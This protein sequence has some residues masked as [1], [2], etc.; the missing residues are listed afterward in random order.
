MYNQKRDMS[1]HQS[2]DS[3]ATHKGGQFHQTQQLLGVYPFASATPTTHVA[4]H[5][6]NLSI[7]AAPPSYIQP[8]YYSTPSNYG[9]APMYQ[10]EFAQ[11]SAMNVPHTGP[12]RTYWDATRSDAFRLME[13]QSSTSYY[14]CPPSHWNESSAYS[15][16][17]PAPFAQSVMQHAVP[18]NVYP[19]PPPAQVPMNFSSASSSLANA[20]GSPTTNRRTSS[21]SKKQLPASQSNSTDSARFF[22]NFLNDQVKE[23]PKAVQQRNARM[24]SRPS[25]PIKQASNPDRLR[26]DSVPPS[27]PLTSL[28]DS[29][30]SPR[31]RK[32]VEVLIDTPSK[33]PS[34]SSHMGPS[35]AIQ[36]TT[37]EFNSAKVNRQIEITPSRTPKM[38]VYVEITPTSKGYV[39]PS[40]SRINEN[41]PSSDLGGYGMDYEDRDGR[42]KDAMSGARST[43]K[44]TGYRDDRVPLEK[45]LNLLEDIFE[46]E[47]NI[48][49]DVDTDS[50]PGTFFSQLSTDPARPLLHSTIIVRLTKAISKVARPTKRIR[51]ASVQWEGTAPGSPRKAGGMAEVEVATLIRLLKLLERSVRAGE[52]L[53]P[54]QLAT[55]KRMS[56]SIERTDAQTKA[57]RAGSSKNEA[58]NEDVNMQTDLDKE[59]TDMTSED[60]SKLA[61]LL[62]TVRDSILAADCCIAL[63]TSD[64]LAKQL[65]SEDL[66][67]SCLSAIKNA[68]TNVI[69]PFVEA[70]SSDA[71][72]LSALL[73]HVTGRVSGGAGPFNVADHRRLIG[74]IFQTMSAVFPRITNLICADGLSMPESLI[75]P[76]VYIAIGPFFVVEGGT[77]S[78]NKSKKNTV[79]A[80]ITN[81]LGASGMR[82]LRLEAL[83]LVRS[84]FAY[85]E[86]QRSWIIEEILTSLIKLSDSKQKAGIFR[87]RDGRSIRTV[88]ALLL[89]LVQTSAH[90]IRVEAFRLAKSR[91]QHLALKRHDSHGS[92]P[93]EPFMDQI[94]I[95]EAKLYA[96]GLEAPT[97]SAKAI[98]AF[99]TQRS[100]RGKSTK[101]ANEV[102]YRAIL[103]NLISDLLLVLFWPEWPAASLLLSIVCKYM[104]SSLEDVKS[105]GNDN[106]ASKAMA[107]D[108]LGTIAGR[109]RS[110]AQKWSKESD[111]GDQ[112]AGTACL[113]SL[114][115]S[116]STLD[117]NALKRLISV[118]QEVS[119]HLSKRASEDHGYESARELN[120]VIWGQELATALI[121]LNDSLS[122]SHEED[123][124]SNM[125]IKYLSIGSKA[126]SALRD[127]WKDAPTD[128]FDNA[129]QDEIDRADRL[130]RQLGTTQSLKNAFDPILNV[131]VMAL[132]APPVFVRTK[133]LRA[134][135]HI[136]SVDSTVLSNPNVRHAIESHLLDSSPQVR[137]AAVELIG[138]YMIDSPAVAGDYYHRVA[139]RIA[140]TGLGVRKR[141]IKLLKAFFYVTDDLDRKVDTCSKLVLRMLDE[142]DTVKD[143][144]VKTLEEI[145]FLPTATSGQTD[146]GATLGIVSVIMGVC[147]IFKDRQAPLEDMLGRIVSGKEGADASAMSTLRSRFT[148]IYDVMIEGLVD[149]SD[150][151]NFSVTNCI[152]TIHLFTVAYPPVMTGS[153]AS[154]LLP[155]LKNSTSSEEVAASDYILKIYRISIPHM[156]KASMKF[157]QELQAILQPMVLKP[158]L[159][160]TSLQ[161]VVAC[162][163]AV[164]R[165]LT[166]DFTR[167]VALLK[168]C[169]ARVRQYITKPGNTLDANGVRTLHIL[170]LIV[171]LLG[172]HFDFDQ[173]RTENTD[174]SGQLDAIDKGPIVEH[175]YRCLLQLYEKYTEGGIR[176]RLL[177]CL[178]FLFRARPTL[179]TLESSAT[180]M[181]AI[182]ASSEEDNRGRLLRLMQEFLVSESAKHSAQQGGP[183]KPSESINMDELVGNTHGFAESGVSSAIVQRYLSHILEAAFSPVPQVQTSAVD[184]L[185][186]TVKQGLAH[187][188]LSFPVIVALETSPVN[189]L[190]SRAVALHTILHHK[191]TSLLNS[192][193]V[194]ACRKS[195]NYQKKLAAADNG[196][197]ELRG[198]RMQPTPTALLGRWYALVREKRA[199]RQEFLRAVLKVFEQRDF[200]KTEEDTVNFVRYMAE[201]FATFDYRTQEEVLTVLKTLTR[202]LAESGSL[203]VERIAPGNLLAQLQSAP[204]TQEG[205]ENQ[206]QPP[207]GASSTSQGLSSLPFDEQLALMRSTCIAGI[208]MLLKAHLKVLYG[209]SEEK[210]QKFVLGKKSAVGDRPAA[211][212]KETVISWDRMPYAVKPIRTHEDVELQ[213]ATFLQIWNEDGATAEPDGEEW[214]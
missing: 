87:L 198:Y 125:R 81:T 57:E 111:G 120:A 159:H 151:V 214:E 118:H 93:Q 32:I 210:C 122:S 83:S 126:K 49:G 131:V 157:G 206:V 53:D 73:M 92:A 89:Q 199:T 139:E 180:M 13:D 184:I 78:D 76:A 56:T 167:L 30:S 36:P 202:E 46:A 113:K 211:R 164:V 174:L 79:V 130:S 43:G 108:H 25:T 207:E 109:L 119:S 121:Q 166:H 21:E 67:S 183:S 85:H 80:V 186:F 84:I 116:I 123:W 137:D 66:I 98:V 160:G 65:F 106:N 90:S 16:Y 204:R 55:V 75:I 190:S 128:V 181:D 144:A 14:P 124:D 22:N 178:G 97:K 8:A 70:P 51:L 100:G 177:V 102:E 153:K 168:S 179:M 205:M 145:W 44:R 58:R 48:S 95:E 189:S 24:D 154:V 60:F 152:R 173:L 213:K 38:Q 192:G 161:E 149:A 61:T 101:N 132:D 34:T 187:P 10:S 175:I 26:M 64:R 91:Q 35:Q 23:L 20:L 165:H 146:R 188:L 88:S 54:F 17:Q 135:S 193:F 212:R 9:N 110:N 142:D 18:Y 171:S 129:T 82:G 182:F 15:S 7:T 27:S 39:T 201:N 62:E 172:E 47:D 197:H 150:F 208:I 2:I 176:G 143:L 203:L 155:Y 115:E 141:V 191:H 163:C 112:N 50:L 103:D 33:R 69:Y 86:D 94:D 28:P 42:N 37:S 148:E 41:P 4:R 114:D 105:S 147:N 170:V 194:A 104:I 127:I 162:L 31:K 134:L 136:L 74:Q 29:Q 68:L 196:N 107:L 169:I 11:L 5:L 6:S 1:D 77:D 209:L 200:S 12:E 19:T 72:D 52:D 185:S 133:A 45:F 59:S 3:R 138:K 71:R 40:R 195:F 99:L 156:P 117:K 63:L 140:D 158:N 96:G